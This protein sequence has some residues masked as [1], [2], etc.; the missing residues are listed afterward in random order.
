MT[1]IIVVHSSLTQSLQGKRISHT[2]R[3]QVRGPLIGSALSQPSVIVV[4][5]GVSKSD[6]RLRDVWD[7]TPATDSQSNTD[8]Q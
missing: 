1:T 5:I 6:S 7:L 8:V 2:H 4:I 3:L